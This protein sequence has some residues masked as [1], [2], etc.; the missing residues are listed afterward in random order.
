MQTC[1]NDV[2]SFQ[3]IQNHY[4]IPRQTSVCIKLLA[5]CQQTH[6]TSTKEVQKNC[7]GE[8][9]SLMSSNTD[10]DWVRAGEG[11]A[12]GHGAGGIACSV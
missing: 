8:C 7:S 1:R 10:K 4:T 6:R 12:S 11:N 3:R 5:Y 9:V 2:C